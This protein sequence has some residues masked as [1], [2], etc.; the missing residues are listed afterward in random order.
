[1]TGFNNTVKRARLRAGYAAVYPNVLMD[2]V[3]QP[4][5][6]IDSVYAA[7]GEGLQILIMENDDAPGS[8]ALVIGR[9]GRAGGRE[10]TV[11]AAPGGSDTISVDVNGSTVLATFGSTYVPTVGDRVRLLWQGGDVTVLD[12]VGITPSTIVT[13][14]PSVPPPS[15]VTV[16]TSDPF[17]ATDSATWSVGYGWNTGYGSNLYQ[18]DGSPW[19]GPSDNRGAWFYGGATARLAGKTIDRLQMFIPRRL[20]GGYFN[21]AA[22]V[23]LYLHTSSTRP[24]GDVTRG[25]V[26]AVTVDRNFAGGFIDLPTAW[27]A[28]LAAGGGIGIYG[29]PYVGLAGVT[30]QSNSGQLLADWRQ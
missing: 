5:Q 2:G 8:M 26:V 7:P 23:Y 25:A 27:G 11:S 6:W 3:E 18:G 1:M 22:T 14:P 10:G 30:Q 29:G 15:Q 13:P 9:N 28:P 21:N 12:K 4:A 16:V 24:S 20:G 17:I 19:G